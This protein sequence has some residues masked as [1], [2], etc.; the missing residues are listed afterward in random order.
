[1]GGPLEHRPRNGTYTDAVLVE[2]E[3]GGVLAGAKA[4]RPA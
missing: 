4:S 3:T 1:M 2:H